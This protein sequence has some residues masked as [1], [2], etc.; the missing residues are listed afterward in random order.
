LLIVL[1]LYYIADLII[2]NR[3][4]GKYFIRRLQFGLKQMEDI[5]EE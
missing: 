2:R 1:L 3:R 4:K 5:H